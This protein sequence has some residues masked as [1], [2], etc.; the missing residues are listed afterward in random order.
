MALS[1]KHID[2]II[3]GIPWIRRYYIGT[4]PSCGVTKLPT[5]RDTYCFITN[6]QHHNDPG[7]HWNSWFVR[8]GLLYF[9]DSYGRGAWIDNFRM[10]IVTS[11]HYLMDLHTLNFKYN[12]YQV[13][14][15]VITV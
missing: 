10:I 5:R 13:S 4:F 15:V 1:N 7:L 8:R 9:F 2:K 12:R 3:E 11:F 14:H 6:V